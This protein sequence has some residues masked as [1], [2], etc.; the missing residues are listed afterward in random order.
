MGLFK[1]TLAK[2]E[3]AAMTNPKP[4]TTKTPNKAQK[5]PRV[6]PTEAEIAEQKRR[7]AAYEESWRIMNDAYKNG[8]RVN[9]TN[10]SF[11]EFEK[12]YTK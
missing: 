10:M 1:D 2:I 6:R 11:E 4:S 9:V 5:A 12:M 8:K 7:D 3:E